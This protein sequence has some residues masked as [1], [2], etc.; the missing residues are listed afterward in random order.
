MTNFF[1]NLEGYAD[2]V[3]L[4]TPEDELISYG[5]LINAADKIGGAIGERCLVFCFSQNDFESIAGYLGM[6]R[7]KI[8]PALIAP[9]VNPEF[10]HQLLQIYKPNYLWVSANNSLGLDGYRCVFKFKNYL[11][12][13]TVYDDEAKP[14]EDLAL[15][16]TTS[17][18]TGS[19]KLVRLSYKNILSN[20]SSIVE[21]LGI[22]SNE[23]PI[24]TLPFYY[25]YGLSIINSHLYRGC[26][27]ILNNHS[28]MVKDFW[29][30][31]SSHKAT[32]FGGVPYTYEILKKL[33]FFRMKIPSLRI[34]TQAGGKLHPELVKEFASFCQGNGIE[35]IV[36]YGQTEATARMSYLPSKYVALKPD[37][38]GI[39]IPGGQF[40]LIN[41]NGDI[42]NESNVYGELVYSGDNVF[43]GYALSR[44]DLSKGDENNRV[45]HTGDIARRDSDGFYFISGRKSRFLKIFGKRVSL[46]EMETLLLG[47]GFE[48]ACT[49]EDDKMKIYVAGIDLPQHIKKY[50]TEKTGIPAIALN[51]ISV[52]SIPRNESGKIMYRELN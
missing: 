34:L 36:M 11:L 39:S 48:S 32:S 9:D 1:N 29:V 15:L 2:S 51:V 22:Y 8:I 10:L 18:S 52:N 45:L 3:A 50:I 49:G 24:T 26:S 37:S 16:I 4:I 28:L 30:S 42:V 21:A 41:D 14:H 19:Q 43:M 5:E 6:L 13:R 31:L 23:R 27:I 38:I 25:A 7:S 35:F 44:S 40:S 47:A 20:T 12:L 33:N 46:D 17:G